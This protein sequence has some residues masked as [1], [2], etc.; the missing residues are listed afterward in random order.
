MTADYILRRCLHSVLLLF[1]VT[2]VVFLILHLVPGDPATVMA[3]VQATPHEIELLRKQMGLDRPLL[4]QYARYM[5]GV[6]RGDLGTS[7][8]AG[9]P[10]LGYVAQ[11]VPASLALASVAF[12]LILGAG[13]PAGVIAAT[14]KGS[15]ID[16]LVMAVAVLGQAVP[17]FWLGL[18]MIILFSVKLRLL[19]PFGF[20]GPANLIMPALTL[21]FLQTGLVARITRSEMLGVLSQDCVRTARA[22]G[23]REHTVIMRHALKNALIPLVTILGIQ[24]GTLMGSAVVT[25]T[26]FAWPGIGS[27]VVNAVYQRDY[28]VV[29]G[30]VLLLAAA[31]VLLNFVVDGLYATLDPRVVYA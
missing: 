10:V 21:A 27:L 19:S 7:I 9:V 6:V 18:L 1:L 30:V 25:E 5:T 31:F 8:R 26:V 3:G 29:Q 20:A 23:L 13:V 11:R 2:V 28:P 12:V 22:K 24:F 15:Y 17:G 16:H 4:A 14:R